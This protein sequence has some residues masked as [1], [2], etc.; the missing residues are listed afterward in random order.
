MK[1]MKKILNTTRSLAFLL[2]ALVASLHSFAQD[3]PAKKPLIVKINYLLVNNKVPYISV[4]VRTKIDKKV[5]NVKGLEVRLLLDK[6]SAG[7]EIGK[8]VT[9][10]F[11]EGV[12]PLP[13][14][15]KDPWSTGDAHK[16]IADTKESK[17]YDASNNELPITK[18]R[19]YIDT[20]D[21]KNVKVTVKE[22]K[23]AEEVPVKGVEVKIGL[24][25]LGA[26]IGINEESAF[27]TDSTG[28]VTTEYKRLGIPGD[29]LGYVVLVA[30]TE[31]NE[32]YGNLR[33]EKKAPWGTKFVF[34][35][36]YFNERSLYAR[37]LESP[38]W[39][40]FV[41]YTIL[42]TVWGILFYLVYI[43]VTVYKDGRVD[44]SQ[45]PLIM[46][47]NFKDKSYNKQTDI[48]DLLKH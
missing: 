10:Y 16:F 47:G 25:R 32:T 39:L 46:G 41:A 18:A 9:N 33:I 7:C 11:G 12:L 13:A 31:D 44:E 14:S 38:L 4:K 35:N 42:A 6:D 2:V 29:S 45:H 20:A 30:K 17:E 23:G 5:V 3:E 36:S 48:D 1:H 26:D 40:M 21:D 28:S 19:I 27:T 34:D 8:V 43:I 37:R 15:L 24:K 22:L